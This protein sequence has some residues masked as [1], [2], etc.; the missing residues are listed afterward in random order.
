MDSIEK[1]DPSKKYT[2]PAYAHPKGGVHLVDD[3]K[4]LDGLLQ[5]LKNLGKKVLE[6]EIFDAMKISRPARVSYH[7]T[8]L[9]ALSNDYANTKFLELAANE[10]DPIK[11]MKYVVTFFVAGWHRNSSECMNRA[12]LNPVLGETFQ[13]VKENGT[14]IYCEQISHHPPISA[15]YM[16][17]PQKSFKIHGTGELKVKIN[18]SH[19]S[20][21]RVGKNTI[22]FKN[23]QQIVFTN[24]E[25]RIEGLLIGDRRLQLVKKCGFMDKINRLSAEVT[26]RYEDKNLVSKMAS[27]VTGF[28]SK[29][30]TP[31]TDYIDVEIFKFDKLSETEIKKTK[32]SSGG[33]SWLELLQFDDEIFWR[34]NDK[35]ESWNANIPGLLP[36]HSKNREDGNYIEKQDWENAQIQKEKIENLQRADARLRKSKKT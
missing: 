33:G 13:A 28:F 27:K 8:F 30:E 19:I 7:K 35:A 25:T 15:F 6:G 17:G 26:F 3:S 32:V 21:E 29:K 10:K 23:G 18:G 22:E 34:I 2:R 1:Y 9:E 5:L 14:S 4:V 20:G 36:S 16:L 12:P 24:P 31:P 11:R